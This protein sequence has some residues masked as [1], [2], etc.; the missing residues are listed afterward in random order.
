MPKSFD[1]ILLAGSRP[2]SAGFE[3]RGVSR[4]EALGCPR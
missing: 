2:R 1:E 4:T 3:E